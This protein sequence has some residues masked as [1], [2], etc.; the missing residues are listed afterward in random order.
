[1]TSYVDGTPLSAKRSALVNKL[2][3]GEK[4]QP[5]QTER[6]IPRRGHDDP[7]PMSFAQQ[8]LFFLHELMPDNPYY[9]AQVSVA[10]E[11]LLDM[12][13]LERA[14]RELVRRHESLRT[15]FGVVAGEP[16]QVVAPA[17]TVRLEG[18]DLR[19]LPA[20]ARERQV[21]RLAT[22]VARRPFDLA[23]GPLLRVLLASSAADRTNH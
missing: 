21:V 6:A 18:W 1:M 19:G 4:N 3:G 15:T 2:L 11:G 14:V 12:H 23:R 8:R 16:V 17:L 13:A 5:S 22:E 9:N 7:T 10:L 20:A